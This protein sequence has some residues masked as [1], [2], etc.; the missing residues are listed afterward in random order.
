MKC[1]ENIFYLFSTESN[2]KNMWIFSGKC[3][4]KWDQKSWMAIC[5]NNVAVTLFDIHLYVD[6]CLGCKLCVCVI[7]ISRFAAGLRSLSP[8]VSILARPGL[9]LISGNFFIVSTHIIIN[10]IFIIII[11]IYICTYICRRL[12]VK[13]IGVDGIPWW[14][15]SQVLT[16]N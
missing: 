7:S 3:S 11:Y 4:F 8:N 13:I 14:S 10:F 15:P 12:A 1:S 6:K 16:T 9:H 5:Y 2:Q